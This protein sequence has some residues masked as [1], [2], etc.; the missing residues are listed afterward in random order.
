MSGVRLPRRREGRRRF[1]V[2]RAARWPE[3]LPSA[4]VRVRRAG[5]LASG[6]SRAWNTS[7]SGGGVPSGSRR[8][9]WRRTSVRA[10]RTASH[11]EMPTLRAF[12]PG[13]ER[14][15]SWTTARAR[16]YAAARGSHPFGRLAP[17]TGASRRSRCTSPRQDWWV[18][19]LLRRG[20]RPATVGFAVSP[21]EHTGVSTLSSKYAL[22]YSVKPAMVLI[23]GRAPT[24]GAIGP[25]MP[26]LDGRPDPSGG[27]ARCSPADDRWRGLLRRYAALQ[28]HTRSSHE[29]CGS[30][31]TRH[32]YRHLTVA[33]QPARRRRCLAGSWA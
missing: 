5:Q 9:K 4:F 1:T 15:R 28:G 23:A 20:G 7:E 32:S 27:R 12:G 2:R 10:A 29:R 30:S 8:C 26:D 17:S 18:A 31:A 21:E 25:R 19:V 16:T 22:G 11:C 33:R 13:G 6:R 3:M 14:D 24:I